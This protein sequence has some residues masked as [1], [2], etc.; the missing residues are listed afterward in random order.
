MSQSVTITDPKA[1]LIL[2][3]TSVSKTVYLPDILERPGRVITIKDSTGLANQNPITL[4]PVGGQGIE[5]MARQVTDAG[6]WVTVI[7]DPVGFWR[8]I[9]KC[10]TTTFDTF[11]TRE[12]T[13]SNAIISSLRTST[14]TT[15]NIYA[16]GGYF[17]SLSAGV[18]YVTIVSTA[19]NVNIGNV[20][21]NSATLSSLNTNGISTC[22]ITVSNVTSQELNASTLNVSS[23]TANMIDCAADLF[24]TSTLTGLRQS[25]TRFFVGTAGGVSTSMALL[26]WT[27]ATTGLNTMTGLATFSNTIFL[28]GSNTSGYNTIQQTTDGTTF[29]S[30]TSA[31]RRTND[32]A[33]GDSPTVF[34]AVGLDSAGTIAYSLNSQSSY[35][36]LT[37]GT[38]FV[39]GM[40]NAVAYGNG[41]F[42]AVG[43]ATSSNRTILTSPNG[44]N[45]DSNAFG[46]PGSATTGAWDVAFGRN[47]FVVV[48]DSAADPNQYG[49]RISTDGGTWIGPS[50]IPLAYSGRKVVYGNGTFVTV[51]YDDGSTGSIYYSTDDGSNWTQAEPNP[52]PVAP[53]TSFSNLIFIDNTFYTVFS[54]ANSNVLLTSR[55]GITW[56]N[57]TNEY[58]N[59]IDANITNFVA[60]T[61]K[62]NSFSA[63]TIPG[64]IV[65]SIQAST[66]STLQVQASSVRGFTF[67]TST[68]ATSSLGLFDSG[69]AT[70][71]LLT[72][73]SSFVK[74]NGQDISTISVK[75]EDLVST[76]VGLGSAS[77]ISSLQL[78]S[79]QN[80]LGSLGY[81]SSTQLLSSQN[82]L[83]SLDYVSSTQLQS[84]VT[85]LGSAS[86]I[87]SLQLLSSQ[88]NLGSLGY[89]S[90]TQLLS[91]QN[92][93]GT[94]GYVSSTQL[95]STVTGLG[96]ASYISSLQLL[97]S[98]NNLGSLGYV[99]STQ[100]QSTVQSI[101]TSGYLSTV[102]STFST[103]FT[104]SIYLYDSAESRKT[105]QALTLSSSYL[106][107]NGVDIS[108]IATGDVSKVDLQS[109]VIG[110]GSAS[111]ISSAQLISTVGGLV[112]AGGGIS[113]PQLQSTV[114]GL[115][116]ASYISSAQLISTVGGLTT[117]GSGI[118]QPQLTSTTVGLG[119]IG[120]LSSFF[121]QVPNVSTITLN[122]GGLYLGI[123]LA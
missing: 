110:L 60:G 13:A 45:F 81:I 19:T 68:I 61:I 36:I 26:S 38:Q 85:G 99:S 108:T 66:I 37:Q 105:H 76:T 84:T 92:N 70:T 2:V 121:T 69:S 30:V 120:Y 91:S 65:S 95:Q 52:L 77:Y 16:D 22:C 100:L 93:L 117:Q 29:T 72:L 111:Y 17:S 107:I 44:S 7:A 32:I 57:T 78:L 90:S 46:F 15:Q 34:V 56:S 75:S 54:N 71:P 123:L 31:L 9:N 51:G 86:Y 40:G 5:S 118:T 106:K 20:T 113:Q 116:S 97:S 14:T 27:T 79:S 114:I 41:V 50:G 53:A 18:L 47:T 74:W 4:G 21:A 109:T 43:F 62:P 122:T 103:I 80:N 101:Q 6:G 119:T 55:D 11:S 115:G 94:A 42:V 10:P 33:Y 25:G 67:V 112:I 1:T 89:I 83:G 104:S 8:M 24:Q 23:V 73:S 64:M 63:V 12:F 88:N 3:D 49:I 58:F 59:S 28:T 102:V 87:S 96:S 82:N 39:G 48:G 98:Q 35:T